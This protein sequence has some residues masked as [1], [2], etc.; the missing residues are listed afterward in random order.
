[1][2]TRSQSPI[3]ALDS[4]LDRREWLCRVTSVAV[5]TTLL[6][7]VSL[8]PGVDACEALES[9]AGL[10]VPGVRA[11]TG[12]VRTAEE[13]ARRAVELA[14]ELVKQNSFGVGGFLMDRT[15]RIVA[16]AT[17]AV[18]RN[19]ELSDPT[20]HVE[21]QLIDWYAWILHHGLSSSSTDLTIV[22][23]LDPCAMCAG[24]ILRSSGVN[25][26]AV[27]EDN[28]AGVHDTFKPLHMPTDLQPLA[29]R[30]M[31]FFATGSDRPPVGG[32]VD[33]KFR[34][35]IS[36]DLVAEAQ[37]ILLESLSQVRRTVGGSDHSEQPGSQLWEPDAHTLKAIRPIMRRISQ[38]LELPM[39]AMNVLNDAQTHELMQTLL[40][41]R[42]A[43][44]DERGNVIFFAKGLNSTYDAETSVMQL[45]RF[46]N[47]IRAAVQSQL[48]IA[49]PPPRTCSIVRRGVPTDHPAMV[50]M[51]LG[52]LGSFIEEPRLTKSLPALGYLK[53]EH[54]NRVQ[55]WA[56]LLPPL[57]INIGI[58][59]G[60]IMSR[61][62]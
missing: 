22:S 58:T 37:S 49:L 59:A 4:S 46:Y 55:K 23:S 19:G 29:E 26:I 3:G 17:N 42:C 20:A 25:V 34:S 13:A 47:S 38:R 28:E 40:G 60:A 41:D 61:H 36:R 7:V 30:R 48:S 21:R 52:A 50:L 14:R 57:Y 51:E 33:L 2:L 8:I 27:A 53:S 45:V 1:M 44:V 35:S 56:E 24:A 39:K 11:G 15:G 62:G 54:I 18:I 12:F 9:P 6:P 43:L 32:I 5:S 16:E 10:G 31:A